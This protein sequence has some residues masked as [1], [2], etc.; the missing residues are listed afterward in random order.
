MMAVLL[1][2]LLNGNKTA[3]E[4]GCPTG[5]DLLLLLLSLLNCHRLQKFWICMEF[6]GAGSLQDIYQG[7]KKAKGVQVAPLPAVHPSC[8]SAVV[9]SGI[10][11]LVHISCNEPA[12]DLGP[13]LAGAGV[14]V[15]TERALGPALQDLTVQPQSSCVQRSALLTPSSSSIC[16]FSPM[17]P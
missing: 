8:V 16:I 5:N 11:F 3:S 2:F 10:V 6:C 14:A 15:V 17:W 7:E 13:G 4:P 12:R 1:K 9:S